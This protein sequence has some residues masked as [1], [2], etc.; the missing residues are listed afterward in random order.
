MGEAL[1]I[2]QRDAQEVSAM[3]M[4]EAMAYILGF[5][6]I[7]GA[8]VGLTWAVDTWVIARLRGK[9]FINPEFWR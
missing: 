9:P 3:E 1:K 7:W 4:V 8:V 2:A 6:T 5:F